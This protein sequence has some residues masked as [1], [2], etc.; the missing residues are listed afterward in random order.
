MY[1]AY[2][3][4]FSWLDVKLIPVCKPEKNGANVN[5]L[6]GEPKSQPLQS[7][8]NFIRTALAINIICHLL[9]DFSISL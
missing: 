5:K 2:R 9:H 1:N 8:L 3:V 7:K 4:W 6:I